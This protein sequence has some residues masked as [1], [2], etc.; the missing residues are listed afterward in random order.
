MLRYHVV[1]PV[2]FYKCFLVQI[3]R[4]FFFFLDCLA[5]PS[6]IISL[7]L[8]HNGI[9]PLWAMLHKSH[10]SL[11]LITW[12]VI[13]C[14]SKFCFFFICSFEILYLMPHPHMYIVSL[15][16]RSPPEDFFIAYHA[17][18]FERWQPVIVF[19]YSC[20]IDWK[21]QETPCCLMAAYK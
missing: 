17:F 16:Y 20:V 6:S 9:W 14:A 7:S 1:D 4:L 5:Y 13:C 15:N 8:M 3:P 2:V 11:D 12:P 18:M 21:Y 19:F 10:I